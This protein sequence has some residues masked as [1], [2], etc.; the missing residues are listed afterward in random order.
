VA[1]TTNSIGI[2]GMKIYVDSIG[3]YTTTANKI[4]TSLAISAGTHN[5]TVQSWD[6]AGRVIIKAINIKTSP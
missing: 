5:L 1:L 3:V 2:T 6:K 4:D